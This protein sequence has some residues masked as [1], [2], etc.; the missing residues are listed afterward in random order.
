MM[1]AHTECMMCAHRVH[2]VCDRVYDMRKQP[3]CTTTL[4]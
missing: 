4:R 3:S 2:D 1:C